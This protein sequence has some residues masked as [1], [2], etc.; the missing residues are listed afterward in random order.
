MDFFT[1]T[2][3]NF[4]TLY[5]FLVLEHGRRIV[6]HF[7]VTE[8]PHMGW[9]VQ[10]LREATPFGEHPKYL[11]RDNDEIYGYGVPRFL[12]NSGIEEVRTAY[13]SPWQSPYVER[14][15]GTLRR[16]LLDHVI[17]FGQEHLER[18]LRAFLE[19][20]YHPAR[21]HQGLDR[22]APVPSAGPTPTSR[23]TR[24]VSV[25]VV[26]G[27]HHRYERVAA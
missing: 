15:S 9:V 22:Q 6:R 4:R 18:L 19:G 1:V 25:P 17:V 11:F 13:R 3:L 10:Q 24:I 7:A 8:A 12:K 5:V 27:L 16:E 26:G 21:P 23:P 20:Y 2:T 14:V